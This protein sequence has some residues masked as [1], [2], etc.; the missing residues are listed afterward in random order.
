ML[1]QREFTL[2][3]V[4]WIAFAGFSLLF[5]RLFTLE[6]FFLVSYA[7]FLVAVALTATTTRLPW[8]RRL[9]WPIAAGFV[10]FVLVV[11]RR[12]ATVV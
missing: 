1:E 3:Q 7:G 11:A 2:V 5:L 8:R 12:V 6:T 10:V 4:A 9:K